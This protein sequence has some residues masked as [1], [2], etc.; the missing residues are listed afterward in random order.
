MGD[1]SASLDAQVDSESR[2][3]DAGCVVLPALPPPPPTS[4]VRAAPRLPAASCLPASG[5]L[6]AALQPPAG[7]PAVL[8]AGSGR[9]PEPA[10]QGVPPA[11]L[12]AG[13]PLGRKKR[14]IAAAVL[15]VHGGPG[16]RGPPE[17][18]GRLA[19][20]PRATAGFL[21]PVPE[22]DA[23]SGARGL[24]ASPV[25]AAFGAGSR[26]DSMLPAPSG[27][28]LAVEAACLSLLLLLLD[29]GTGTGGGGMA[30]QDWRLAFLDLHAL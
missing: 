11:A 12:A 2:R 28:L 8:G 20:L 14:V 3:L 25:L 27:F 1:R 4:T 16:A 29:T 7:P 21:P 15:A 22:P 26:K 10:E 18:A 23:A 17:P 19:L 13:P 6:P 9:P 24:A 30:I 5:N